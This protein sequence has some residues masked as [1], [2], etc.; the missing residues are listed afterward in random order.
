[1]SARNKALELAAK[2][3]QVY[4]EDYRRDEQRIDDLCQIVK[5]L[6]ELVATSAPDTEG[7]L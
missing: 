5:W 3:Q 4:V 1:M 6:A 2:A 7:A